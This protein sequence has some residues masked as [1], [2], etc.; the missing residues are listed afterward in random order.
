VSTKAIDAR[1]NDKRLSAAQ[2]KYFEYSQRSGPA[3]VA[4][5]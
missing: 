5:A 2:P 1:K 4:E 3:R